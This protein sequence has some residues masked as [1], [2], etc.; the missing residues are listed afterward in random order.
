MTSAPGRL[1]RTV[2]SEQKVKGVEPH[3][4]AIIDHLG[5]HV[6]KVGWRTIGGPSLRLSRAWAHAWR[7][8]QAA[9]KEQR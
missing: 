1:R 5:D 6:I 2:T 8:I 7:R 4:Y 9:Q 3:A